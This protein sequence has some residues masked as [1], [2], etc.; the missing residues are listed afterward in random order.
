MPFPGGRRVRPR[1]PGGGAPLVGLKGAVWCLLAGALLLWPM[2]LLGGPLVYFDSFAYDG[3]G[4]RALEMLARLLPDLR[5]APGA[6]PETAAAAEPPRALRSAAWSLYLA[7]LGGIPTGAVLACWLQTAASLFVLGALVPAGAAFD[8]GRAAAA[9]LGVG[10]AT[11]LPW[12]ASYAMPDI[13][14]ALVIAYYAAVAGPIDRLGRGGRLALAGLATF[15]VLAHYGHLPLAA[16]LALGALALRARRMTGAALLMALAP[17]ALAAGLNMVTGLALDRLAARSAPD[18]ATAAASGLPSAAPGRLPILLARSIEDGPGLWHLREACARDLYRSCA[19]LDPIPESVSEFLWG[20]GGVRGL[21][22][23]EVAT[24]RAEEV[25]IVLGAAQAYPLA[26]ATALGRNI[27]RQLAELGTDQLLPLPPAGGGAEALAG[28]LTPLALARADRLLPVAFWAALAALALR[29]ALGRTPPWLRTPALIVLGGLLANAAV[30][31]GLSYP[32]DR[33]Q[34]RLSWLVPA[35][36][37]IDL[38]LR[39]AAPRRRREDP[40]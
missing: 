39:R 7:A 6:A 24:L 2:A 35:L 26:Q 36:L 18:A 21:T 30:F 12:Y 25:R 23:A 14:G 16:A 17:L 27:A 19:A 9:A 11:S 3:A 28:R 37:A 13:L 40:V 10:V 4:A 8:A 31:G 22:A 32:V 15:A 29:L 20:D 38:A 34:A 33:Y 1:A 5:P